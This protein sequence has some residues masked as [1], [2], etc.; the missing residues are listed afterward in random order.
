MEIYERK[1]KKV[2]KW[3][4]KHR[5][6]EEKKTFVTRNQ[7]TNNNFGQAEINKLWTKRWNV[8]VQ[9][10]KQNAITAK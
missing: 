5:I 2:F 7:V 1:K 4:P 10:V 3:L 6:S 9:T 8:S